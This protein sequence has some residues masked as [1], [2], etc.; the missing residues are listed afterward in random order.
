M[1]QGR[2]A[3]G[4]RRRPSQAAPVHFP[5]GGRLRRLARG[6]AIGARRPVRPRWWTRGPPTAS[7]AKPPSRGPASKAAASPAASTCR[8]STSSSMARSS[9]RTGSRPPSRSMGSSLQK[10]I[11]TTCGSGVTAAILAL[12]VE[13][14]GGKVAGPVRRLLGRMGLARR[15]PGWRRGRREGRPKGPGGAGEFNQRANCPQGKA[16]KRK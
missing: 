5:A 6:G 2:P 8:L 16:N 3:A 13:E 11:I 15:L 1:D 14:A 10:P 12:A 9:R 4:D 7:A